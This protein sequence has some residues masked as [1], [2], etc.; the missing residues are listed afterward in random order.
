[1]GSFGL[2]IWVSAKGGD[3]ERGLWKRVKME[4]AG[5][6]RFLRSFSRVEDAISEPGIVL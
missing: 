6:V 1:M 5:W 3:G 2:G 4:E